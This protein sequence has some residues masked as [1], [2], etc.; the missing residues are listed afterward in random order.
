MIED[1]E[2]RVRDFSKVVI[3]KF[4]WNDSHFYVKNKIMEF[5]EKSKN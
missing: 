1:F 2:E 5:L 4:E 3:Y